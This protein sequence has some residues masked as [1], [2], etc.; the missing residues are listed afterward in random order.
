MG[1]IIVRQ[2]LLNHQ[3]RMSQVPMIFFYAAPTNRSELASLAEIASANP[4]LRGMKP[5]E[6]NDLLQ[7]LQ[8]MWLSSQAAKSIASYCRGGGADYRWCDGCYSL[9]CDLY[10]QSRP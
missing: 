1:G 6:G 5:I 8:S 4:Q 2:F 3:E 7:S 9:E 10:V